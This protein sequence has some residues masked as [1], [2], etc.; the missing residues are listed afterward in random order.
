[1]TPLATPEDLR[2]GLSIALGLV[3]LCLFSF[4][5]SELLT[6]CAAV[7]LLAACAKRSAGCQ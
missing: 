6:G 3:L 5:M 4:G 7:D 2:K 1:M